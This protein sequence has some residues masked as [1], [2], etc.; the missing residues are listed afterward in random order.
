MHTLTLTHSHAHTH[1]HTHT[2]AHTRSGRAE[3]DGILASNFTGDKAYS[4]QQGVQLLKNEKRM[5]QIEKRCV[6]VYVYKGGQGTGRPPP[7]FDLAHALFVY[8]QWYTRTKHPSQP[9]TDV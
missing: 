5:R 3:M 1:T 9:G 6:C 2:H 8:E 7:I 4:E